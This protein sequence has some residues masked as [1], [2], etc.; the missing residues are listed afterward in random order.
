MFLMRVTG[1]VRMRQ[2][3]M[4]LKTLEAQL[5][6][7]HIAAN[8]ERL[9]LVRVNLLLAVN[10][11][12]VHVNLNN[13]LCARAK[14]MRRRRTRNSFSSHSTWTLMGPSGRTL[15]CA[16]FSLPHLPFFLKI[17]WPISR[18]TGNSARKAL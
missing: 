18:S 10:L 11:L 14:K 6:D 3:E 7:V 12:V 9:N 4:V 17:K 2:G 1:T 5:V 16:V 15:L 8:L 13:L